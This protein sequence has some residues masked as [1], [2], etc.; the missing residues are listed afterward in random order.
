MKHTKTVE[1][2]NPSLKSSEGIP[3]RS[4][5]SKLYKLPTDKRKLTPTHQSLSDNDPRVTRDVAPSRLNLS[6]VTLW[7]TVPIAA[8]YLTVLFVYQSAEMHLKQ[9]DPLYPLIRFFVSAVC[10]SSWII[11]LRMLLRQ[12]DK[13]GIRF[14]NYLLVYLFYLLPALDIVYGSSLHTLMGVLLT[15]IGWVIFNF[16]VT[17]YLIWTSNLQVSATTKV[18]V[19]ALPVII[20]VTFATLF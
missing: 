13:A 16:L 12:F 14:S 3:D 2:A 15:I 7:L 11:A 10:V 8:T 18:S 1:S 5:L 4:E 6:F 17:F 19:I 20:L 9:P